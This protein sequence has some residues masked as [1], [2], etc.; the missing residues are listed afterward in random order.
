MN[1]ILDKSFN[2]RFQ[3]TYFVRCTI[4]ECKHV[5]FLDLSI[6]VFRGLILLDDWRRLVHSIVGGAFNPRFQGTYFVRVE[7]RRTNDEGL[8]LS[9]P[10]FR[11][12]ILLV[13]GVAS[14][15][16]YYYVPFNPRFQGTYFV[17]LEAI[18]GSGGCGSTFNPRFQGT[19]F[20]RDKGFNSGNCAEERLSIPVFRG[21]I[22]LVECVFCSLSE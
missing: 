12:L 7:I 5:A 21:L 17:R 1:G 19:Y 18:K 10:V 20:V 22:L 8:F 3:G 4:L 6:P 14:A 11:G 15:D 9:I 16:N 13:I 2:P